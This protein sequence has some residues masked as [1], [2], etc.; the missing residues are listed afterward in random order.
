MASSVP[1]TASGATVERTGQT[2]RRVRDRDDQLVPE[3]RKK[4]FWNWFLSGLG[5]HA[6]LIGLSVVFLVPFFWMVTGAF[7]TAADLNA[8]GCPDLVL[9]NL[10]LNSYLTASK[11]EPA[12]MYVRDFA[13]FGSG[14]AVSDESYCLTNS[15]SGMIWFVST[16]IAR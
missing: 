13:G 9:G 15:S 1:A 4:P 10:G 5:K 12:R 2:D 8:D 7:K 11:N 3:H 6:V 16:S 14:A